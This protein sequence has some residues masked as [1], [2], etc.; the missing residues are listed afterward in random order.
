LGYD[1]AEIGVTDPRAL[2]RQPASI[3]PLGDDENPP[4]W[5]SNQQIQTDAKLDDLAAMLER[6]LRI[7]ESR[8]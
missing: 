6:A 2:V 8:P 4:A 1:P 7:L 5:F 3:Q